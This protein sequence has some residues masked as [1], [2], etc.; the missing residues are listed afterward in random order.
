[1]LFA[2]L[3][4]FIFVNLN[5]KNKIFAKKCPELKACCIKKQL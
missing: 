1:M 4:A 5:T 2:L 3:R